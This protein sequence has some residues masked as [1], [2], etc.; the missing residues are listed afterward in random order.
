LEIRLRHSAERIFEKKS[1]R[2]HYLAK[3][4][5]ASN[6]QRTLEKGFTIVRNQKGKIIKDGGGLVKN[7]KVLTTFR[8]G[9]RE[10]SV[11]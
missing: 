3:S 6:L 1:E 4:L 9:E 7:D 5:E 8:D 11:E 10:M 2:I